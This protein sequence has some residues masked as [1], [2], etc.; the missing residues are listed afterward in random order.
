MPGNK[1]IQYSQSRDSLTAHSVSKTL[2]T[3]ASFPVGA[4]TLLLEAGEEITE[5]FH[6]GAESLPRKSKPNVGPEGQPVWMV[7]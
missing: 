3:T 6:R 2:R 1:V 4:K 7:S 5:I